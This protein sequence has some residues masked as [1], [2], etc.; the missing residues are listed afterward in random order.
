MPR[1]LFFRRAVQALSLVL[2]ALLLFAPDTVRPE[3]F[4]RFDLLGNAVAALAARAAFWSLL[5]ALALAVVTFLFGRVFCGWACPLGT[6]I[7]GI[8]AAA[9]VPLRFPRLRRV[10]HQ[11]LVLLLVLAAFG[12]GAAWL[13][14]PLVWAGRLLAPLPDWPWAVAGIVLLAAAALVF[15][16][17][18]FC[19]VL[20]PLG[21]LLGW[22]ASC[23][24]FARTVGPACTECGRCVGG[25]RMAALGPGASDLLRAECVHCRECD[26]RC[27][28]GAI[29]FEYLRAPV[30]R[31]P[32]PLR[33]QYLAALGGGLAIGVAARWIPDGEE[34]AFV[35]RP[36]GSLP[37]DGF[38]ARCV[39]CGTCVRVCPTATLSAGAGDAGPLAFQAPILVAR[40]GGC[41]YDCNACGR[42]CPTGAIAE[43]PLDEK[44]RLVIGRAEIDRERCVAIARG[45]P[46]LVCYAACPLEAIALDRTGMT[47]RHGIPLL[48]PRVVG[49]RCTG[50]GLCEARCPVADPGAIRVAPRETA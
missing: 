39:R 7:D 23:S 15:G 6:V 40:D 1:P 46:C 13:F 44:R 4:Y 12:V 26:D 14:D 41:D 28:E 49:D 33:R 16:R 24:P 27:P 42:V 17:R 47:T 21:A 11:L 43:L 19:R 32:D 37:E 48:V 10:K 38:A 50:C 34:A 3:A 20:C 35:L 30:P 29:E 2:F 22:I 45:Q 36:P 18:A 31:R 9:G 5:F 25:C 8:D